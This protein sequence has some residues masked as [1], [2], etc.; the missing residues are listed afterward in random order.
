MKLVGKAGSGAAGPGGG[1]GS[2]PWGRSSGSGSAVGMIGSIYWIF[3]IVSRP[4]Q[5]RLLQK[6][7]PSKSALSDENDLAMWVRALVDVTAETAVDAPAV[8]VALPDA[9]TDKASAK[10]S[11]TGAPSRRRYRER[12]RARDVTSGSN[13]PVDERNTITAALLRLGANRRSRRSRIRRC[14]SACDGPHIDTESFD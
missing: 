9:N 7:Q 12:R 13:I 8:A 10:V 6:R 3:S 4:E 1:R 2:V 5:I 11:R 14:S